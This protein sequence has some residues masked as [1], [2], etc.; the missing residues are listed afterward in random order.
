MT[1]NDHFMN[2]WSNKAYYEA[3]FVLSKIENDSLPSSSLM[4]ELFEF[5]L[6]KLKIKFI[7]KIYGLN[8]LDQTKQYKKISQIKI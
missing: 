1:I 3:F 8:Y 6:V 7:F 4:T 5:L 2:L